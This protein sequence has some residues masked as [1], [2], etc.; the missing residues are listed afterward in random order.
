MPRPHADTKKARTGRAFLRQY[1]ILCD[2][3]C[4]YSSVFQRPCRLQYS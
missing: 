2:V 1:A 3:R 4:A